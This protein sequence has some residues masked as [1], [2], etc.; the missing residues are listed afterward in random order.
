MN[1]PVTSHPLPAR[2][3]G[4]TLVEM[5]VVISIFA[6]FSTIVLVKYNQFNNGILLTDLAYEVALTIRQAQV[7]G[8]ATRQTTPQGGSL[9][10]YDVAYGAR[11]E[12]DINNEFYF[13]VDAGT[14]NNQCD[15]SSCS[16]SAERI[17]TLTLRSNYRIANFCAQLASN[18]QTE[19]MNSGPEPS[20]ISTL[21]ITFLRPNPTAIIKTNHSGYTYKAAST[22]ITTADGLNS[23]T[24]TV[25]QTG[26][27]TVQ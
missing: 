10:G 6:I 23:R 15:G 16:S 18:G 17:E 3:R 14:K 5:M 27:I 11:F 1:S 19:C 12:K 7:Y 24:V 2:T 25:Q 9:S 26:Q 21:D 8:V 4:L 20:R 22:T 13:Y